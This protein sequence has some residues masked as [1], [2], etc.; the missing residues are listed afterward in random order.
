MKC[1][2]CGTKHGCGCKARTAA[3]GKQCCTVCVGP[4]NKSIGKDAG[5][6]PTVNNVNTKK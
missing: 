2:N 5:T 6:A 3:D 4:Y 1:P